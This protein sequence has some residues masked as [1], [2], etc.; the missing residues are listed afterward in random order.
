LAGTFNDCL[1]TRLVGLLGKDELTTSYTGDSRYPS[2]HGIDHKF[3]TR[4]LH[5]QVLFYKVCYRLDLNSVKFVDDHPLVRNLSMI[6]NQ[7]VAE[8][9]RLSNDAA[10][11]LHLQYARKVCDAL[12]SIGYKRY[13]TLVSSNYKYDSAFYAKMLRVA[14]AAIGDKYVLRSVRSNLYNATPGQETDLPNVLEAAVATNQKELVVLM[15][16]TCTNT[17]V[18]GKPKTFTAFERRNVAN[19]MGKALRVAAR[20][21]H[22]NVGFRILEFLCHHW[23]SLG[24]LVFLSTVRDILDDCVEYGNTAL[25]QVEGRVY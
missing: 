11:R 17:G 21:S 22:N 13:E 8:Q 25:D 24:S 2:K 14:Y 5:T 18:L 4:L 10:K 9:R 16:E 12:R 1:V 15:L 3:L 23:D 19:A 20:L 6:V 7:L